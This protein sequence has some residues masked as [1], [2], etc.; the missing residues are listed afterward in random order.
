MKFTL[1][2]SGEYCQTFIED[3]SLKIDTG[4][5][6]NAEAKRLLEDFKSAVSDL[7]WFINATEVKHIS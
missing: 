4:F 5:L 6:N 3:G 7:E 1:R 2:K